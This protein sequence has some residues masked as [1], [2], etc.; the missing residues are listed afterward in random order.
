VSY[1]TLVEHI[2]PITYIKT[3]DVD[4]PEWNI[5]VRYGPSS[6]LFTASTVAQCTTGGDLAQSSR[7]AITSLDRLNTSIELF[8]NDRVVGR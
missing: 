2:P 3:P 6:T 4:E 7:K 5:S 1:R 8:A